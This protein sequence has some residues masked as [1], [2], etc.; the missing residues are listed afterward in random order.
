M[1]PTLRHRSSEPHL[2]GPLTAVSFL[3]GY[4]IQAISKGVLSAVPTACRQASPSDHS[5]KHWERLERSLRG[6]IPA[7]QVQL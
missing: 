2:A 6:E 5:H 3:I 7:K 4:T 1:T